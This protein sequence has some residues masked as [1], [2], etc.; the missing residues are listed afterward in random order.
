MSVPSIATAPGV[1]IR[2]AAFCVI[3]VPPVT[4]NDTRRRAGCAATATSAQTTR[5]AERNR[6]TREIVSRYSR[7]GGGSEL[8]RDHKDTKNTKTHEEH[9]F[10]TKQLFFVSPWCFRV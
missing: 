8:Y 7:R 9:P 3:T 6:F 2:R 10:C 5:S 4:I 1:R